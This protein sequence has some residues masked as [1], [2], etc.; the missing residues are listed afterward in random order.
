MKYMAV[1]VR[2]ATPADLDEVMQLEHTIWPAGTQAPREK[3]E[4]RLYIFPRGFY[5]AFSEGKMIGASTS[6]IIFYNPQTPPP[7]WESATA[8]GWIRNHNPEGNALYVVSLGAISRSG[9]GTALLQA[10]KELARQLK[11]QYLVLGSRIPGYNAYC[12]SVREIPIEAYTQLKR[13]DTEL[14]DSEL[15]FYTRNGLSIEKIV[16]DYMEDDAESRNYG[17]VMVWRP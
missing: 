7:S 16:P 2:N 3:F 13:E 15:R 9:G 10:Q 11:L 5:V 1:H 12:R 14:L 6:Q 17:A 4:S 8:H